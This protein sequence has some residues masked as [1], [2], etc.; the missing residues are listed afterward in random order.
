MEPRIETLSARKLVG[1]RLSM[2]IN[3]NATQQLWQSFMPERRHIKNN[4]STDLFCIQE[5]DKSLDFKNFTPD[6][7]FIKWAAA[8]VSDFSE[9]PSGMESFTLP[10]GLYAVFIYKGSASDFE[11][12]F[13]Y[14][15]C[16]WLPQSEY[17]PD[18]RPHFEIL[19]SKYK[20]NDPDSEEELW[21]PI[22]KK[23][24]KN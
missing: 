9:I 23:K 11:E 19:G 17:E 6:T 20:N 15:F 22:K 4:L 10:T 13:R 12:T 18:Q 24:T 5:Y 8:E 1:K 7:E 16:Q 2:S 14:I 3:N 21:I